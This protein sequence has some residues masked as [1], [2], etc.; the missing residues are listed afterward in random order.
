MQATCF[1]MDR[2]KTVQVAVNKE[3]NNVS[4]ELPQQIVPA[5]ESVAKPVSMM[6]F[7]TAVD[8]DGAKVMEAAVDK[9]VDNVSAELPRQ[10]VPA[11]EAAAEPV[12][13]TKFAPAVDAD[14]VVTKVIVNKEVD[15]VTW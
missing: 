2:A 5:F 10:I 9:E 1:D 12:S 15:N 14:R 13:M 6:K 7:A 4:A 8:A 3:V 11:L